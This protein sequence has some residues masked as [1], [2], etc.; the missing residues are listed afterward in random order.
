M[1]IQGLLDA[2]QDYFTEVRLID[3]AASSHSKFNRLEVNA[4]SV[5]AAE[6]LIVARN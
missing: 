2:A 5:G 4:D 1:S 6:V 3:V